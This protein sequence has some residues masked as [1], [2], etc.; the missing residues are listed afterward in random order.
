MI[1]YIL[2]VQVQRA[3]GQR[4]CPLNGMILIEYQLGTAAA[5]VGEQTFIYFHGLQCA[6][7]VE[8]GFF[9]AGKDAHFKATVFPNGFQHFRR[10]VDVAQGSGGKGKNFLNGHMIQDFPK[11][12]KNGNSLTNTAFFQTAVFIDITCQTGRA[13][14]VQ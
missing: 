4:S 14:F 11:F 7:I 12:G 2:L 13:F 8:D 10:V 3:H 1:F 5:D 9:F 6:V